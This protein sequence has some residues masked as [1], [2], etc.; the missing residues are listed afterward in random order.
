MASSQP[1]QQR[2]PR[3]A[4]LV[5]V[6]ALATSALTT[7]AWTSPTGQSSSS[8]WRR[9]RPLRAD[10]GDASSSSVPLFSSALVNSTTD[11]LVLI[12]PVSSSV[13]TSSFGDVVP[14]R[15]RYEPSQVTA[16]ADSVTRLLQERKQRNIGVAI[17]SFMLA[18]GQYL[19]V[20][21]HPT[22]TPV[23][24]LQ[25]L[26][27]QSPTLV[28]ALNSGKPTIIDF[29]APWCTNCQIMAPTL[30]AVEDEYHS[31]DPA[32]KSPVNIISI[33]ADT[34]EAAVFVDAF[35]VDAIPHL[36]FVEADGVVDT[37]LIGII[38]KHV[39]DANIEALVQ[40]SQST[41]RQALPYTMLDVFNAP[42]F[43]EGRR[44]HFEPNQ[45]TN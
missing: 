38:P 4:M 44:V 15:K 29:W 40:N 28:Q 3:R 23:S 34:P 32:G 6:T 41:S 18:I 10:H 37:A 39:I 7:A 2:R 45:P 43:S 30:L 12:D 8:S 36:A 19:Y 25:Q 9:I 14:L 11:S 5:I 22:T 1:K 35:H 13:G 26:S 21:F 33:N 24:I 20:F 42:P 17:A 27:V 16:E 31:L